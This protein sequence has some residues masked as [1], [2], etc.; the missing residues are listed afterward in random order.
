VL[1]ALGTS[2]LLV[3]F[4]FFFPLRLRWSLR[5]F[6]TL[7]SSRGVSARSSIAQASRLE[8]QLVDVAP[9]PVLT[10]L[11]GL[12]DRVV[13]G[14][15]MPCGVLVLR[16]VTAADVSTGETETQV[17]PAISNFQAVLTFIQ[18]VTYNERRNSFQLLSR[19]QPVIEDNAIGVGREYSS[20]ISF[21]GYPLRG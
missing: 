9:G 8:E 15:E 11:E 12:N 5:S 4:A 14:V 16:I 2:D 17:H 20:R 18:R 6:E 7:P 10:R 21:G 1:L 13:G 19:M 3:P